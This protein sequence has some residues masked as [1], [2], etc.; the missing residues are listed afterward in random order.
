MGRKRKKDPLEGMESDEAAKKR[1]WT[2][3]QVLSGQ[4]GVGE[5]AKAAQISLP[6][7]Y[8][9]EKKALAAMLLA[10]SPTAGRGQPMERLEKLQRRSEDLEQENARQRQL[11]RMAKRL[12]GPLAETEA[13]KGRPEAQPAATPSA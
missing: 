13:R 12:W 8:Q 3:L 9:L 5:A 6:R 7:Y 4:M 11:L 1:V 10:L 2:L